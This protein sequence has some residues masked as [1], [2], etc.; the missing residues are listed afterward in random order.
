MTATPVPRFYLY[1]EPHRAVA[2]RF[3]HVERLDDRTRPSE[4]TIRPHAHAD[5]AHL[6]LVASGGGSMLVEGTTHAFAAPALVVV[7]ATVVHGFC[8]T[9]ESTGSVLTLSRACLDDLVARDADTA[10]LFAVPQIL[11]LDP[12]AARLAAT[13][14]DG[15]QRELGWSAPGR[16]A[17]VDAALLGL[18]VIALRAR[19]AGADA[20]VPPPPGHQAALVARFRDRIEQRFRLRE[21]VS[22]HAAALGVSDSSLRSACAR[23]AGQSPAAMIDQRALLEAR[24]ALV[25]S[26]LTIAEVGYSIG[27]ADPAYFSRFYARH[28][29]RPPRQ[30]RVARLA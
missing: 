25:Y 12:D 8:W 1:G 15:A 9:H 17:A 14:M 10:A 13:H 26:N 28:A 7:P 23:V 27:F 19:P 22:A 6:F 2:D 4:W 21:P 29:G 3:V 5:L 11:P 16:R 30:D 20:V 18:I 24:R